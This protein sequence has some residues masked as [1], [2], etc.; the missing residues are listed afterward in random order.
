MMMVNISINT[1]DSS[2]F[3]KLSGLPGVNFYMV[4]AEYPGPGQENLF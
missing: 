2:S 1:S 4:P 3:I